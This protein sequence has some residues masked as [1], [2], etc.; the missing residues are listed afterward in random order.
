MDTNDSSFAIAETVR[1]P[2]GLKQGPGLRSGVHRAY[3]GPG[4]G[5]AS[6]R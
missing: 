3:A 6:N 2:F 4:R 5:I 1:G